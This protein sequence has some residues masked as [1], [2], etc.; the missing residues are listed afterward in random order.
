MKSGTSSSSSVGT[1]RRRR[2]HAVDRLGCTVERRELVRHRDVAEREC[3]DLGHL[4]DRRAEP[5]VEQG[6]RQQDRGRHPRRRRWLEHDLDLVAERKLRD[7]VV[8]EVARRCDGEV[9]VRPKSL[10]GALDVLLGHADAGVDDRDRVALVAVT[11]VDVHVRVRR[12]E[13]QRV[14]DELGNDVTDVGDGLARNRR[15]VDRLQANSAVLLDLAER[16]AEHV[17]R[18]GPAPTTAEPALRP[19]APAATRRCGACESRG[20]RAGT[21]ARAPRRQTLPAR[22][23]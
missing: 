3:F 1:D 22:G 5:V 11:S 18:P 8:T 6:E 2:T 9:F 12:R 4:V 10:V 7:D 19:R 15:L 21:A 17:A 23:A 14:L 13:R 16:G 20:G